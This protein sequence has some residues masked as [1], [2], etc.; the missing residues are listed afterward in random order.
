[1]FTMSHEQEYTRSMA[2][3]AADVERSQN[4]GLLLETK[5][6]GMLLDRLY[7]LARLKEISGGESSE[8][9][10]REFTKRVD[11]S[12]NFEIS[13]YEFFHDICN[14]NPVFLRKLRELATALDLDDSVETTV[15]NSTNMP[16]NVRSIAHEIDET[17]GILAERWNIIVGAPKINMEQYEEAKKELYNLSL[18]NEEIRQIVASMTKED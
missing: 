18:S 7:D 11:D 15:F 4:S 6:G 9:D 10:L 3:R 17:L 5:F 16:D 8:E 12:S 13:P 14:G 2:Q 1:M